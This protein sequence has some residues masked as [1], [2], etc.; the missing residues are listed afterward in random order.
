MNRLWL[1]YWLTEDL[2][3]IATDARSGLD[4]L[5]SFIYRRRPRISHSPLVT[6]PIASL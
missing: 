6:R 4:G 5:Q 1:I 3:M 2:R